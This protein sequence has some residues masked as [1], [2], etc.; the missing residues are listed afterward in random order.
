MQSRESLEAVLARLRSNGIDFVIGGSG[1]MNLLGACDD[2]DDWDVMTDASPERVRAALAGL[3]F[4]EP[5]PQVPF[6]SD[7]FFQVTVGT[8][9]VDVICGFSLVVDGEKVRFPALVASVRQGLPLADPR[10]WSRIY[11]ALGQDEK[12]LRMRGLQANG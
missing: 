6:D 1:M 4:S 12:A 10:I 11:E 5:A 2:F 3:E 9:K 7:A 8:E